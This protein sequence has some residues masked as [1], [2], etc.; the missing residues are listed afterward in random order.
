VIGVAYIKFSKA[1]EAAR[2]MEEMNGK[3]LSDKYRD[4]PRLKVYVSV[5]RK[6]IN[7]DYIPGDDIYKKMLRIFVCID[8]RMNKSE[9]KSVFQVSCR[10]F[11]FSFRHSQ[12]SFI[13]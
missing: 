9:L 11:F 2:A 13:L 8:K 5:S 4:E 10:F 3:H 12:Y 1:S 6:D 7:R